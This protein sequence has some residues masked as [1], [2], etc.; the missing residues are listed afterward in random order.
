[1]YIATFNSIPMYIT[2]PLATFTTYVVATYYSHNACSHT[3][4]Y[5]TVH[6]YEYGIYNGMK[7]HTVENCRWKH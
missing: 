3:V 6:G 1:M 5:V 2:I 7:S 4:K